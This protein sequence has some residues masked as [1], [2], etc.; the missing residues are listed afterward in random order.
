YVS[1]LEQLFTLEPEIVESY[2]LGIK[3]DLLDRTLRL[4]ANAFFSDW[5]NLRVSRHPIDPNTGFELATPFNTDDG[6]AEVYGFETEI[7]WYITDLFTFNFNGGYLKTKYIDIGDPDVSSLRFGAPFAFAPEW[8]YSVGAQYDVPLANDATLTLRADYGW[9]DEYEGDPSVERHMQDGPEPDYGLLNMRF[10]Y[11]PPASS[12]NW[13]V[14][15][16]GTN[17]TDERYVDG[18]FVSAGLGF[19]LDTVGPPREY[20]L[21]LEAN[22]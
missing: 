20:G 1:A 7:N 21:T 17:L 4:N 22:F 12:G 15:L 10:V 9:Q 8:S 14:A 2:E 13:R 16:W 6:Q 3:S 18:G 11:A 19:S 5:N